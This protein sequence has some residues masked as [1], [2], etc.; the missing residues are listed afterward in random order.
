MRQV[1][2]LILTVFIAK[3]GLA[4]KLASLQLRF[5]HIT[6]KDGLSNNSVKCIYKDKDGF[7]WFGTQDGLNRYDGTT[8]KIYRHDKNDST[9]LS[10]NPIDNITDDRHDGLWISSHCWGVTLL[11]RNTGRGYSLKVEKG[12]PKA[13]QAN[14]DVG[15]FYDE[16]GQLWIKNKQYL[17]KYNPETKTCSQAYQLPNSQ[18]PVFY[19]TL[20][21]KN[22]IWLGTSQG[23]R[24]YDI[25]TKKVTDFSQWVDR[26]DAC[27]PYLSTSHDDIF[28]GTF[29]NG[30]YIIN[31]KTGLKKHLLVNSCIHDIKTITIGGRNQ[32]WIATQ[33]GLFVAEWPADISRFTDA[34]F[35]RY[36]PNSGQAYALSS[37]SI[38]C[39][40]QD[41]NG[42]IWLG[43]DNGVNKLN[44]AYLRF[45]KKEFKKSLFKNI[46]LGYDPVNVYIHHNANG[47][48]SYWFPY[49][50]GKGLIESDT[51]FNIISHLK[52]KHWKMPPPANSHVSNVFAG[53]GDTLWIC[54]WDGLWSYDGLKKKLLHNNKLKGDD[55][56]PRT[57]SAF[58]YAAADK[59]GKIWVGTYG[60][61]LCVFDTRTG[62]WTRYKSGT[63][64]LETKASRC[65]I[66]FLDAEGRI[67]LSEMSYFDFEKK[68]FFKLPFEAEARKIV[69]DKQ[70]HIWMA[71]EA[72]LA[73][74]NPAK[75]SFTTFGVK[76][77]FG[78][79][80]IQSIELDGNDKLWATS[81]GGLSYL[82][83]KTFQVR[84][85]TLSDGLPTNQLGDVL[86]LLPNGNMLFNYNTSN[87]GGFVTFSPRKLIADQVATPFHFTSFWVLGKELIFDK[88]LDSVANL[89][90]SYEQNLLTIGFKALAFTGNINIRYRY[91][92]NTTNSP[93]IDIGRESSITFSNLR[94]GNYKLQVQSTDAGGNWMPHVLHLNI[95]VDPPFWLTWWFIATGIVLSGLIVVYGVRYRINIIKSKA[96]IKQEMAELQM[97][98]LKAQMNPHFIFNS[99]SSIQESIVMGKTA[100]ASKYLGMFSKLIRMVL[101]NSDKKLITLQ[102]EIDYLQL[103]LQLESFRFD[104]L[105]FDIQAN[106]V[107]DA[108]FIRIPAMLIQPYAENAIKHGLSHKQGS[109]NLSIILNDIGE[110][111]LEVVIEDNG[112]GR[113]QSAIINR[114]G[115]LSHQS[116]AMD[117]TAERLRLYDKQ[118]KESVIITDLFDG[119]GKAS[120]TRVTITISIKNK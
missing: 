116:M 112:I 59:R 38:F 34:S 68:Q 46:Q 83:T 39:I 93:W 11:N 58:D 1:L 35:T 111:F 8:F 15:V 103:Y 91:K 14:C 81:L 13:L 80:N 76:D 69:E 94:G 72:G 110:G 54:T 119:D 63:G 26:A 19:C 51:N 55:K 45:E 86:Q 28:V 42:I 49:W 95:L 113:E 61:G 5:E 44:P 89:H 41:N 47:S 108:Q 107:A 90:L 40:Y 120:G 78:S 12:N 48:Y 18:S 52:F 16:Y 70:H 31:P 21:H 74:Y 67:W 4:Q 24:T 88:P 101:E 73:L 30:L 37:E 27:S 115:N 23:I 57:V 114:S 25:K 53:S 104:D 99:L 65:D 20:Y 102:Q 66:L 96:S 7:L 64:S 77:G 60:L 36:L 100:V 92:L 22:N 62:T 6:D 10:G 2:F 109:K 9:S 82:D 32:L 17:S 98:A 84:T 29:K 33:N 43:T 79:N 117:I 50:H 87:R 3:Y 85:F 118:I 71:T 97:K 56:V 106:D 75:K 105:Y